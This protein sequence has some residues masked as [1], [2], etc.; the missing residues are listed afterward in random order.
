MIGKSILCAACLCTAFP[1][2]AQPIQ[3]QQSVHPM[4]Q[5]GIRDKFGQLSAYD[6]AFTVTDGTHYW[7]KVIHVSRNEWGFVVFPDEFNG[8]SPALPNRE[9]KWQAEV[10]GSVVLSGTFTLTVPLPPR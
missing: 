1:S 9:Y 4:Y 5:L 6:A 8:A 3:W 10:L 7:Q 2:F